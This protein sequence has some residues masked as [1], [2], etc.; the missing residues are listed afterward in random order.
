M[1]TTADA[2][3]RLR[4]NAL[5][6]SLREVDPTRRGFYGWESGDSVV[7]PVGEA[8]LRGYRIGMEHAGATEVMRG[9][10]DV[11]VGMQG[12]AAEGAAMAVA[13]RGMLEPWRRAEFHRLVSVSGGR[14]AY[15]MHVGLGWA[16]ARMPLPLWPDL[17]RVDP[18]IGPLV[19]D[20]YG[21]HE[22][23][24]D[25]AR[26]LS[27]KTVLR[28]RGLRRERG[29]FP[30]DRWP[31]SEQDAVQ[32][33]MQG[34][35]RG[36]WFVCGGSP[37]RLDTVIRSFAPDRQGSMWAGVGLAAT[38]AGGRDAEGLREL[39]EAAGTHTGWLRQGSAFAAEAR[40]RAGTTTAHTPVAV[41]VL[42]GTDLEEAVRACADTRPPG[43]EADG[44]DWAV[45]ERWRHRLAERLA[46]LDRTRHA[47]PR[48]V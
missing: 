14:H 48:P 19:L 43:R 5:T 39:K 29:R 20:G 27:E 42:C 9:L 24:F 8:F 4:A 25:T 3:R 10:Q 47:D 31:G 6:P 1:S 41:R 32:Q 36:L 26:V 35:G 44:G 17:H 12:F 21:F 18:M 11:P 7:R 22:V 30:F 46:Q 45:Y 13:V 37:G 38:Y 23:F 2:L 33:L 40:H 15:M 16:L 28:A 34:V